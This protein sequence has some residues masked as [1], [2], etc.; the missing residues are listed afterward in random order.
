MEQSTF[1][2]TAQQPATVSQDTAEAA[3]VAE[4]AAIDKAVTILRTYFSTYRDMRC[5]LIVDPSQ[6]D[7]VDGDEADSPFAGLPHAFVEIRHDGFPDEHRPYLM[8]LDVT[9]PEGL[10]LLTQSVRLAYEDRR[11]ASMAAGLG[12]RIGGWLASFAA[13]HDVAAHCSRHALQ[14]DEA[15]RPCVLRF[16][17]ARALSLIWPTLTTT[18]Q[19]ALLG[20]VKIWHALDACAK[21]HAYR[22]DGL[23]ADLALTAAQWQEIHR[24]GLVNRALALHGL[25][26][27]RQPE[28]AEVDA[29]QAA[30]ARADHYGLH[31]RDDRIAF[32]GHA[33]AWHPQ[34]D[35]HPKVAQLLDKKMPSDFYTAAVA[36]LTD[37]DIADIRK[38]A[39]RDRSTSTAAR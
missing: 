11:P 3:K 13:L 26:I 20:P 32:V 18:Q 36:A 27:N 4:V 34:F 22:A 9:T 31:D 24:H 2:R 30:A 1:E 15:G 28:P 33:L 35:S 17:D 10:A 19:Q 21:P 37:D 12:Q 8:Q 5:F 6:R 14:Y 7:V 25:A 29:A 39:W 38:G 16:Y 23:R